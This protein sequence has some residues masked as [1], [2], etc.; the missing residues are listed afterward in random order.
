MAKTCSEC[1]RAAPRL[2]KERCDACYMRLYRGGE[3]PEGARCAA[4]GERRRQVLAPADLGGAATVLCGNCAL[5]LARVRPRPAGVDE[6]VARLA[7]DRRIVADRRV[8]AA[9][10]AAAD[11]ERRRGTRRAEDRLP[12]PPVLDPSID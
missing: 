8:T 10:R 11:P 9:Y 6:L 5:V 3:L 4:C 2:R 12:S 7:R 1:G